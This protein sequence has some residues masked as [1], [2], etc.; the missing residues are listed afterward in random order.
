MK[1]SAVTKLICFW[2]NNMKTLLK[3]IAIKIYRKVQTGP[4]KKDG[5]A[6]EGFV[7]FEYQLKVLFIFVF[8]HN[9]LKNTPVYLSANR[10]IF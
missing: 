1:G 5:G 9:I 2:K 3:D 4:N 6:Q 7:K 10:S 8:Y